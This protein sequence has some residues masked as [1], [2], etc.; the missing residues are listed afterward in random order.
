MSILITCICQIKSNTEPHKYL[1]REI[2][3]GI[4]VLN[5]PLLYKIFESIA[6]S[7][8]KFTDIIVIY[9]LMCIIYHQWFR[10]HRNK[11]ARDIENI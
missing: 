8:Y 9:W 1:P 3:Y 4:S 2:A 11:L 6:T 7:R 5:K 10:V